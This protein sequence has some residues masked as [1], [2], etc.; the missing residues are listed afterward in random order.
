MI[1]MYINEC[2]HDL[3]YF[4]LKNGVRIPPS[5]LTICPIDDRAFLVTAYEYRNQSNKIVHMLTNDERRRLLA[6][7]EKV[8][9]KSYLETRKSLMYK[10]PMSWD[11]GSD[12]IK[13]LK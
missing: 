13:N 9:T 1:H 11:P 6:Y 10:P 8:Q 12:T 7:L 5:I 2:D 4:Y 3:V